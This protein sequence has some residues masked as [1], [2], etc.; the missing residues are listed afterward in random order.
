MKKPAGATAGL[1]SDFDES[2]LGPTAGEQPSPQSQPVLDL[3]QQAILNKLDTTPE[4]NSGPSQK[5]KPHPSGFGE[6]R[7]ENRRV[8]APAAV[9]PELLARLE[10]ISKRDRLLPVGWGS[11]RKGPMVDDWPNHP[12]ATIAELS[13]W[14]GLQSIG[15]IT[16]GL[17]CIDVDGES[18][19]DRLIATH[20]LDPNL[21]NS[22]RI[23]RDNDPFRFKLM[24]RPTAEQRALLPD[25]QLTCKEHTKAKE[26]GR[27]GE[28]IEVF[29]H[30]GRQVIVAGKHPSSGGNY[31]WPD[32]QGPEAL[33]APPAEWW[34][35]VLE[36]AR[37]YP[38]PAAGAHR[39]VSTGRDD[40]RTLQRCPICGRDSNVVCQ[41]HTDGDTI[42][43]FKGST[44]C[45]PELNPGERTGDWRYKRDQHVGWGTFAIFHRCR[46]GSPLQQLRRLHRD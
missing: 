35:Y 46:L 9:T 39:T 37:D 15:V 25:G 44:F 36:K 6:M 24:F 40:W 22:W 23:N 19:V 10:P 43:C 33:I 3:D 28:A 16:G 8:P 32:G 14:V 45:P 13:R 42:R 27:K 41:I 34:Q 29:I 31:F 12:G 21:V 20:G 26:E 38:K 30:P 7:Q 17:L 2:I 11:E 5:T 18:A 1:G 4:S